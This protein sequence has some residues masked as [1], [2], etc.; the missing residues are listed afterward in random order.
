MRGEL[1]AGLSLQLL[2]ELVR[3]VP[4]AFAALD[5]ELRCVA[6]S[7][8]WLVVHGDSPAQGLLGRRLDEAYPEVSDAWRGICRRCLEGSTERQAMDAFERA[9]GSH[10]HLRWQVA[11]W[12][13]ADG[14][15]GGVVIYAENVSEQVETRRRLGEHESLVRD[16]FAQSPL[17]LNLCRMDGLW[18]QS[19]DAFLRIIGYTREEADRELTYWQLTPRRYDAEEVI[20][21]EALRTTRR[22]GPYNKEFIRKDGSLV[23]VRL[24]GFLIERD[25]ESFIWSLIEDMTE[26]RAL[27]RRLE[28]EQLKAIQSSK[29][30]MLGE[31]AAGIAHEINN[32]L[33]AIDLYAYSLRAALDAGDTSHVDEVIANIRASVARAGRIVQGLRRFG[34]TTEG[35]AF[36]RLSIDSVLED[37]V[38]LC[39][40]RLSTS[41]VRLTR[42]PICPAIV[43]GSGIELSQVLINLLN[44]AHDAVAATADPW[45]HL[46]ALVHDDGFVTVS[47]EDSGPPLSASEADRIFRPFFTTKKVGQG[48]GLGLSISRSIVDR[49]GG[50][51]SLEVGAAHPR[52]VVRLPR[53]AK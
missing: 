22:Y 11:P 28:E 49:H 16:F 42:G 26:Q 10:T 24:H 53:A 36:A 23:P 17:G 47:V 48:T 21:L 12:S 9:D 14:A 45:V 52:F 29:L 5:R 13:E 27:E 35:E 40:P 4:I 19:N 50:T 6:H 33:A 39:E 20:Q 38:Q 18:L 2:K 37:A 7:E 8:S 15:I 25:G 44:N 43:L 34:R 31:M 46:E 30:A 1:P 32:P 41:G 3:H 51:L